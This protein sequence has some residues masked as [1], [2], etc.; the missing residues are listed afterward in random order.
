MLV[1]NERAGLSLGCSSWTE[2][3][4]LMSAKNTFF[5][6]QCTRQ[7]IALMLAGLLI[8]AVQVD[9]LAQTPS[10]AAYT[11]LDAVQLDQLVAPI[12][13]YPDALVAQILTAST[14]PDQVTEANN[15]LRENKGLPRAQRAE[16]VNGMT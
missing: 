4:K 16:I 15:W 6:H 9:L 1:D 2:R 3:N 12:S 13:L 7:L 10:P 11:P 14:Y 8:P 5:L